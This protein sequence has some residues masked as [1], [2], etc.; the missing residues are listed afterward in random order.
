MIFL[1]SP[2]GLSKTLAFNSKLTVIE[3]CAKSGLFFTILPKDE[4]GGFC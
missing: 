3:A 1:L 2:K 4:F